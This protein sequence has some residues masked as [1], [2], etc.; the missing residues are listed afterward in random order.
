MLKTKNINWNEVPT[1]IKYGMYCKKRLY[2]VEFNG[3]KCNRSSYEFKNFII[4]FSEEN[5]N[6][7]VNKYWEDNDT[8][9]ESI[10]IDTLTL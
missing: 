6:M 7:L 10:N 4:D 2:E 1:F 3:V 9:G 5:I 8:Y